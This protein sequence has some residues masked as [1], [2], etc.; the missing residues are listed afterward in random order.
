MLRKLFLILLSFFLPLPG[1][2]LEL[3]K[4]LSL[5]GTGTFVYQYMA[6]EK[7][8]FKDRDRGSGVLDLKASLK[9]TEKDEFFVRASFAQGSGLKEVN[10]FVL[11]LPMRM[12]FL[13]IFIILTGTPGIT[14]KSFGIPILS[15]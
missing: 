5:L 12:T 13:S 9:P 4:W 15:P 14:F 2:C 7:G 8:N 11:S 10:P 3:T 1:F 6:K